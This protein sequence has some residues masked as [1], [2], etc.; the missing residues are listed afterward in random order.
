MPLRAMPDRTATYV[1]ATGPP[2]VHKNADHAMRIEDFEKEL[3][4]KLARRISKVDTD[5]DGYLSVHEIAAL[6]KDHEQEKTQISHLRWQLVTATLLLLC[7]IAA[8]LGTSWYAVEQSRQTSAT[9]SANGAELITKNSG[10][11]VEVVQSGRVVMLG[12]IPALIVEDKIGALRASP[13]LLTI[14]DE[15]AP[16]PQDNGFLMH[17]ASSS[18]EYLALR[19]ARASFIPP[20]TVKL[21]ATTG[22]V[23]IVS[24]AHNGTVHIPATE[25]SSKR[26]F[27]FC[28][29]CTPIEFRSLLA[30]DLY[31][32]AL[33][34]FKEEAE[35]SSGRGSFCDPQVVS[36]GSLQVCS[37]NDNSVDSA[38]KPSIC[39]QADLRN[40]RDQGGRKRRDKC[41]GTAGRK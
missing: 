33:A 23:V 28:A 3:P 27:N 34:D 13:E 17:E 18:G 15:G 26:F 20:R 11:Q 37:C 9:D 32:R 35:R 25:S 10:K 21:I 38:V 1:E 31:N 36:T 8:N 40:S 5:G 12:M 4:P 39:G 16:P 7:A 24:G 30:G 6:F 2:K 19:I 41:G 22:E 14:Y 29:A